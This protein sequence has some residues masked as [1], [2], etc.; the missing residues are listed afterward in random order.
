MTEEVVRKDRIIDLPTGSLRLYTI[1]EGQLVVGQRIKG[2]LG[3][4][5]ILTAMGEYGIR[6][7][8]ILENID[9][10]AGGADGEV[11]VASAQFIQIPIQMSSDLFDIPVIDNLLKAGNADGLDE[12]D[13]TFPVQAGD[14]LAEVK[15]PPKAVMRNPDGEIQVLN[16]FEYFSPELICGSN[17]ALDDSGRKVVAQ[18]N[19]YA[20]RTVQGIIAVYPGSNMPAIGK[21]HARVA[22]ESAITVDLDVDTDARVKL[23]SNLIVDGNILGAEIDVDGNVHLNIDTKIPEHYENSVIRA[24]QSV[25]GR[26]LSD[27]AIKAGAY[28][29]AVQELRNCRVECMDSVVARQITDS[30]LSVG[31]CVVAETITGS[32]LIN[33]ICSGDMLNLDH[34]HATM[35]ELLHRLT[36]FEDDLNEHI[37]TWDKAKQSLSEIARRIRKSAYSKEQHEKASE[38]VNQLYVSLGNT[39]SSIE[40]L[41]EQYKQLSQR[42]IKEN[43]ELD[44]IRYLQDVHKHPSVVVFGTAEAGTH[45]KGPLNEISIRESKSSVRFTLD[46]FTGLLCEH[47]LTD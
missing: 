8:R 23:P 46:S 9:Y 32:T 21:I 24:G 16:I 41:L 3:Q 39:L 30:V 15:E 35:N 18:V 14:I 47:P 28:V 12:I 1:A 27:S 17:T 42:I 33:L 44:Q 25:R 31:N 34:R 19:G 6:H 5:G 10:L 11:P 40:G 26:I 2:E 22:Q 36:V 45:I 4:A 7:G 43:S 13:V 37:Y 38:A 29:I 20:H